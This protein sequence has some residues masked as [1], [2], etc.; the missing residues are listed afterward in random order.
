M[1]SIAAVSYINTFPFI[2]GIENSGILGH[3]EYKLNKIYPSLCSTAFKDKKADIVL[4]PSGTIDDFD[5]SIII[6]GTCIGAVGKVKSVMLFSHKPI[7]QINKIILDYQ[8]T[9]SVKL[10]KILAKFYW[11]KP[12]EFLSSEKGY[13]EKIEGNT[14]GLIIGDRALYLL[15]K[16][17]YI[18]DLATEWYHFQQLPFVFAYWAKTGTMDTNFT[19]KFNKALSWGLERKKDALTANLRFNKFLLDYLENDISYNMDEKKIEGLKAFYR[20]SK[21]I[22]EN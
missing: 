2:Y 4:M 5:E 19:E 17:E 7:D 8:S 20:L 6:K 1:I 3:F 21:E 10:V 9:T 11:N 22:S 13:E 16:F 12:M 18:Y 14:A 15:D